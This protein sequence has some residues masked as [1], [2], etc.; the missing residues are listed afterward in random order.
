MTRPVLG[1]GPSLDWP[2]GSSIWPDGRAMTDRCSSAGLARAIPVLGEDSE[3]VAEAPS[4]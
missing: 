1:R 4:D 2:G 3:G